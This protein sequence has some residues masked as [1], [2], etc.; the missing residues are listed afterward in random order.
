MAKNFSKLVANINLDILKLNYKISVNISKDKF[1]LHWANL[2]Q[3][4]E[5]KRNF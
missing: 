2:S 5:N 4:A 3:A 1:K